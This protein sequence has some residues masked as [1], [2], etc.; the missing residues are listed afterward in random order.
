[1][2]SNDSQSDSDRYCGFVNVNKPPGLTSFD[3]IRKLRKILGTRK[4]GHSG[5]LDKPATGVLPIA[6]GRATKLF[7]YFADF[8]K[9]YLTTFI[10][11]FSTDTD[12]ILGRILQVGDARGLDAEKLK[13]ELQKFVGDIV[14]VPPRYSTTKVAGKPYYKLAAKGEEP[15]RKLKPVKVEKI[16]FIEFKD[17]PPFSVLTS[18]FDNLLR[19]RNEEDPEIILKEEPALKLVTVRILCRGGFYVRSLAR[20]LGEIL[21]VKGCVLSL[22]REQVGP[23]RIESAL[24]IEDIE[25]RMSEGRSDEVILPPSILAEPKSSLTLDKESISLLRSGRELWLSQASFIQKFNGIPQTL[26]V[27]DRFGELAA[28]VKPRRSIAEKVVLQPKTVFPERR[29]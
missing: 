3:V 13:S 28:V 11:G 1:M 10:F 25:T 19:P 15:P 16:E 20:D 24:T 26:F 9:A 21:G 14:Q 8:Q 18:Q 5:V 22:V 6:V 17:G 27:L 12:D 4:L 7:K 29:L 23:L 2:R